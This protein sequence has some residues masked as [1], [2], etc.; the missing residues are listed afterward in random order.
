[1]GAACV[2]A[3]SAVEAAR[4]V[5]TDSAQTIESAPESAQD[6]SGL[7]C[8]TRVASPAPIPI[9]STPP[10]DFDPANL[11]PANDGPTEIL[12]AVPT[13]SSMD[14]SADNADQDA[15]NAAEPQLAIDETAILAGGP[16]RDAI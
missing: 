16:I 5:A 1:V 7:E 8:D 13:E 3:D 14:T 12:A 15:A 4:A 11:T 6:A 2:A 9:L 10:Q